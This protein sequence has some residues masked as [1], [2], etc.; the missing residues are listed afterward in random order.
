MWERRAVYRILLVK[1]EGKRPPVRPRLDGRIIING[2]SEC[3][4]EDMD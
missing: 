2:Y 3:A 4:I 1:R